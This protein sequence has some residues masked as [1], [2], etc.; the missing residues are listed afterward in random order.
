MIFFRS[1]ERRTHPFGEL[2]M[3]GEALFELREQRPDSF[4]QRFEAFRHKL[5]RRL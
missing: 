4:A 5:N 1:R 3:G 2:D